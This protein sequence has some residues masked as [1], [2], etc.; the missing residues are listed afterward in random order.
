MI[1]ILIDE[2]LDC[3]TDYSGKYMVSYSR[4]Y[5]L[6]HKQNIWM[7]DLIREDQDG[8]VKFLDD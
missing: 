7:K 8:W 2:Y 5:I 4:E 3:P 6:Y 1:K